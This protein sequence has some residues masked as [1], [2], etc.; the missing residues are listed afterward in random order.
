MNDECAVKSMFEKEK[1][2]MLG[3]DSAPLSQSHSI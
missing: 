2:A 1:E 3:G